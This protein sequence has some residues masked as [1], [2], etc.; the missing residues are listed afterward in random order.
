MEQG[1]VCRTFRFSLL[2]TKQVTSTVLP[3][4]TVKTVN[5]LRVDQPRL[6]FG[7]WPKNYLPNA[8]NCT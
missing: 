6:D 3:F 8:R 4:Q 2:L 7:E 5:K 1:T